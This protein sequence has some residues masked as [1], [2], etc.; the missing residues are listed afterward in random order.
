[1]RT[2]TERINKDM[3]LAMLE[4]NE[5]NRRI[6]DR[7]VQTL[8]REMFLGRWKVNGDAIRFGMSGR[9]L[10]GQHRLWAIVEADAA[11]ETLVIR[12][13]DDSVF[14]T[15]DHGRKRTAG[16]VLDQLGEKY[17]NLLASSLPLLENLRNGHINR[18]IKYTVIEIQELLKKYPGIRTSISVVGATKSL[19]PASAMS[20]LHYLFSEKDDGLADRFVEKVVR[21]EGLASGEPEYLLRERLINNKASRT[22]HPRAYL[23]AITIKAWNASR[24]GRRIRNLKFIENESFPV[25]L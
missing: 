21:G 14:D 24:T 5:N 18:H 1:M 10:D 19:I 2:T 11:I 4:S 8:A 20:A 22:K 9:L 12:D 17:A 13:L 15:I 16:D 25:I 3:A 23:V 6:N 7:Q